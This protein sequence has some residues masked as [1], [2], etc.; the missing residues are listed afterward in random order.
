MSKRKDGKPSVAESIARVLAAAL[1]IARNDSGNAGWARGAL[2]K[3]RDRGGANPKWT[4]CGLGLLDRAEKAE[5]E[6]GMLAWRREHSGGNESTIGR[7]NPA[8]RFL[9]QAIYDYLD[10]PGCKIHR[11][12]RVDGRPTTGAY[13]AARFRQ[14]TVQ[15]TAEYA[16]NG[17]VYN[18]ATDIIPSFNDALCPDAATMTRVLSDAYALARAEV[19]RLYA[20]KRAAA[21]AERR[22]AW[23]QKH[24][25]F[26]HDFHTALRRSFGLP[27]DAPAANLPAVYD[28]AF[29]ERQ[30]IRERGEYGRS[31]AELKAY[32][33]REAEIECERRGRAAM[34]AER[35]ETLAEVGADAT[36]IAHLKAIESKL[37]ALRSAQAAPVVGAPVTV[38]PNPSTE[39]GNP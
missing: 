38:N 18:E 22:K 35:Q 4:S 29:A 17:Q 23:A 16:R 21:K 31:I 14:Q 2:H 8:A 19:D 10:T 13:W 7:N 24:L 28:P 3:H 39:K 27:V 33:A 36:A 20:E 9:V 12:E 25:P 11:I 15:F 26:L 32:F 34:I 30:A 6:L 37:A 5:A 1:G